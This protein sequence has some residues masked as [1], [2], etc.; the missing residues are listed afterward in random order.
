MRDGDVI[1]NGHGGAADDFTRDV[2]LLVTRQDD[3]GNSFDYVE[4]FAF[5]NSDNPV[6]GHPLVPLDPQETVSNC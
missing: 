4:G 5:V 3:D 1:G 6:D 2:E